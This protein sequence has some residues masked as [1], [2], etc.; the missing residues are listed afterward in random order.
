MPIPSKIDW[1]KFYNQHIIY[2]DMYEF[3]APFAISI[4]TFTKSWLKSNESVIHFSHSDTEEETKQT[5]YD[6]EAWC[7]QHGGNLASIHTEDEMR[8]IEGQVYRV[9]KYF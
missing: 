8:F 5:W 6:A 3:A 2:H 9:W 1:W 4:R 7:N